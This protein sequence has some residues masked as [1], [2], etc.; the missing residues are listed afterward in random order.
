MTQNQY[1]HTQQDFNFNVDDRPTTEMFTQYAM[2][3]NH[4]GDIPNGTSCTPVAR[5]R[6]A[7][8]NPYTSTNKKKA[9][10]TNQSL[11]RAQYTPQHAPPAPVPPARGS[12]LGEAP[13]NSES[14]SQDDNDR[15]RA[16]DEQILKLL[17]ECI[18]QEGI[19]GLDETEK[20]AVKNCKRGGNSKKTLDTEEALEK[21]MFNTIRTYGSNHMKNLLEVVPMNTDPTGKRHDYRFYN[22][23]S[24]EKTEG[25]HRLLNSVFTLLLFKWKKLTGGPKEIGKPL[26]P[27]SFCKYM[28]KLGYIMSRKGVQYRWETDF[29]SRGDFHGI[30]QDMWKQYRKTDRTYGVNPNRK[31]TDPNLL[32]MVVT[33]IE[34]G[35]LQ[36]YSN[37]KDL[38]ALV[39]FI[40]GYYCGLRGKMEHTELMMDDIRDGIFTEAEGSELS[41]LEY[42]GVVLP[43]SKM[44]QLKFNTSSLPTDI[45][46]CLLTFVEEDCALDPV[47]IYRF[48]LNHCH[49]DAEKFYCAEGTPKQKEIWSRQQGKPIWFGPSKPK[50]TVTP[51]DPVTGKN[52]TI[53]LRSNI[54]HN[55][56]TKYCQYIAQVAG[57][58]DW[59]KCTGH[60][61]RALMITDSISNGMTAASVAKQARH[62]SINSQAGY[63]KEDRRQIGNRVNQG[64]ARVAAAKRKVINIDDDDS[65]DTKQ[66]I[67]VAPTACSTLAGK[68][69]AEPPAYPKENSITSPMT[70]KIAELESKLQKKKRIEE[71]E[72]QLDN[73]EQVTTQP[74]TTH[75]NPGPAPPHY[76]HPP[77]PPPQQQQYHHYPAP[78]YHYPAPLPP[79]PL[80][81]GPP[82][83][84]PPSVYMITAGET[85]RSTSHQQPTAH[86]HFQ[87]HRSQSILYQQSPYVGGPA[88]PVSTQYPHPNHGSF[89]SNQGQ[90][91]SAPPSGMVPWYD[92][93]PAA[94]S[95]PTAPNN[96]GGYWQYHHGGH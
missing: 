46:A 94:P 9:P 85:Y 34:N 52:I 33:A 63:N 78:Q 47:K 49:V 6:P 75:H 21:R 3:N 55:T 20:A 67:G 87:T 95:Q 72:K 70:A 62:S 84:P 74:P 39:V 90:G 36:P 16:T 5:P 73:K 76:Q 41:G 89:G 64:R 27:N 80:P 77:P 56:I 54:G 88:P 8:V 11:P 30:A 31:R 22:I 83:P 79:P 42:C 68:K 93:P 18:I 71:L 29:N 28:Q 37:P 53:N 50:P 24:G 35:T 43:F 51:K 12:G 13:P 7:V 17:N 81:V 59:K 14:L 19:Q 96:N 91:A 92:H 26:Q 38:L 82:A 25:K 1:S 65:D 61:L 40:N 45:D 60:A 15:D 57:V 58:D 66:V 2:G 4:H 48:Y 23:V 44:K 10:G 32:K 86:P 69:W